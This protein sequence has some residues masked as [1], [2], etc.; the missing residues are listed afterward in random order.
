MIRVIY[1]EDEYSVATRVRELRNEAAGDAGMGDAN[2]SLFEG[3]RV[4]I[5]QVLQAAGAM[6]FLAEKRVVI[7]AGMLARIDSPTGG[8]R[9][10]R[11]SPAR[12]KVDAARLTES[13]QALPSTTELIFSDGA[14]R[15]NGAGLR[16][17]GPSARIEEFPRKSGPALLDWIARRFA[18]EKA[19]VSPTAVARLA[20]L[21]GDN[22][23]ALDQEVRKLATYAG[24]APVQSEDVDLLVAPAR[25]ANVFA[26]VDAVLERRLAVATRSFYQLLA[27]GQSVQSIIA[28]I[29]TQVRR[30]LIAREL[31]D[32]GMNP[33]MD[34]EQMAAR[35]GISPGFPLRR[36]V[37]QARRFPPGYMAGTMRRLLEADLAIKNGQ[38]EERLALE[39]LAARL[40]IGG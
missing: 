4:S 5:D 29:G 33:N 9:G 1:G 22:T 26:A 8:R 40:S 13:I 21:I 34:R 14:L 39:L 11:A 27:A 19:R 18:E 23:R 30:A 36:T 17:A 24:E 32:S 6:P 7:V 16:A 15:K 10:G 25:E 28:L 31:L 12:A 2:L 20:E 37:E 35:L 3:D 38:M